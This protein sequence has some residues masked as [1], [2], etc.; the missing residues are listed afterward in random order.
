MRVGGQLKSTPS[1]FYPSMLFTRTPRGETTE[2]LI[3]TFVRKQLR[4]KA[5]TVTQV[6]E[7]EVAMIVHIDRPGERLLRC[8][9][10][11]LRCREVPGV[12]GSVDAETAPETA[13]PPAAGGVPALR[14]AGGRTFPGPSRGRE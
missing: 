9:V 2:V 11:G 7:T 8:G 6:E 4:L 12:A 5:H 14:C 10:C 13:L 1:R 3:E